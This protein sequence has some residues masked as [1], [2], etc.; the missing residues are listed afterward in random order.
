[1]TIVWVTIVS[2][3]TSNLWISSLPDEVASSAA[4][5]YSGRNAPYGRPDA[6]RRTAGRAAEPNRGRRQRGA[7]AHGPG[8]GSPRRGR[9][10]RP[11]SPRR[12]D[13]PGLFL[14]HTRFEPLQAR[15][16]RARPPGSGQGRRFGREAAS[17]R[18]GSAPHEA[19]KDPRF[20]RRGGCD[21][22]RVCLLG[23]DEVARTGRRPR[24]GDRRTFAAQALLEG[25]A[26]VFRGVRGR[27]DRTGRPFDSR[28]DLRPQTE[29]HSRGPETPPG[30]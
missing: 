19:A 17:R 8:I 6:H 30:R 22:R 9:G 14:R 25:A 10:P 26:R 24:N 23:V 27:R 5:V 28:A 1:M 16:C 7:Q 20:W 2:L 12:P 15:R 11:R 21:A 18:T 3:M 4:V 29:V 13:T